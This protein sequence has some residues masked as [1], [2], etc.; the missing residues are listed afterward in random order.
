MS[1]LEDRL[2]KWGA[3]RCEMAEQKFPVRADAATARGDDRS[4]VRYWARAGRERR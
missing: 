1:S 4:A 2:T 3:W